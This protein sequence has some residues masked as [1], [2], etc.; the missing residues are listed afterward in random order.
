MSV[1]L[2]PSLSLSLSLLLCHTHPR[3]S[4]KMEKFFE[5]LVF[6]PALLHPTCIPGARQSGNKREERRTSD[7]VR[8]QEIHSSSL[9]RSLARFRRFMSYLRTFLALILLVGCYRHR[10]VVAAFDQL[11]LEGQNPRIYADGVPPSLSCSLKV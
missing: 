8:Q 1:C 6:L 3:P 4:E 9:A 5:V 11:V 2:R 7:T 10:L